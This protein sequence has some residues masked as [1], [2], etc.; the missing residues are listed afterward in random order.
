MATASVIC[1]FNSIDVVLQEAQQDM[2]I[3]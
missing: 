3:I 2:Q 1:Y